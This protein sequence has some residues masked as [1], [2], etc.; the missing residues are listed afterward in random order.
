MTPMTPQT[1]DSL[2]CER[3]KTETDKIFHDIG[4]QL[5]IEKFQFQ[6]AKLYSKVI[7]D[8]REQF[9][10]RLKQQTELVRFITAIAEIE[11][12]FH[13]RIHPK[14]K[15][16]QKPI[17]YEAEREKLIKKYDTPYHRQKDKEYEEYQKQIQSTFT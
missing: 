4:I 8:E 16:V 2:I 5:L 12:Q 3:L 11:I 17:D 13:E 10:S 6:Q 9:L 1:L 7:E 14:P 15:P